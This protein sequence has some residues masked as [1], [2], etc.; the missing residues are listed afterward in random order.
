MSAATSQTMAAPWKPG[1]AS[2]AELERLLQRID[3]EKQ[4][5][6]DGE[7]QREVE[8]AAAAG[9]E[10]RVE[11]HPERHRHDADE[12]ADQAERPQAA[13]G[14]RRHGHVDGVLERRRRLRLSST[15]W[16]VSPCTQGYGRRSHAV[17]SRGSGP[18]GS[19]AK[20]Q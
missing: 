14:R 16:C 2:P 5:Q 4:E 7:R 3:Q 11:Q 10:R 8:G 12:Q 13:A 20:V 17:D 1:A 9:L 15:T 6:P 19:C 18:G